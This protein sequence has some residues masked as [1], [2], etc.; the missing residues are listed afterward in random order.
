MK[1]VTRNVFLVEKNPQ[2]LLDLM[3]RLFE[4]ANE[5]GLQGRMLGN[6]SIEEPAD[7]ADMYLVKCQEVMSDQIYEGMVKRGEVVENE[8]GAEAKIPVKEEAEENKTVKEPE[9]ES[10]NQEKDDGAERSV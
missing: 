7:K 3:P 6:L 8:K 10:Q 1:S 9:P 2:A 4:I 5:K